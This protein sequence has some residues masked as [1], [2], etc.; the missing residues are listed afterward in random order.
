MTFQFLQYPH[1]YSCFLLLS[2]FFFF[3]TFLPLH[4]INTIFL[5]ENFLHIPQ[6]L[7]QCL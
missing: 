3:L 4:S 6:K 2:V 5:T 1:S 7:L